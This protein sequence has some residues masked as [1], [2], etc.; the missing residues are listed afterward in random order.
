MKIQSYLLSLSLLSSCLF[1]TSCDDDDNDFNG[2][3]EITDENRNANDAST[4]ASLARWEM[5]ATDTSCDY[6]THYTSDGLL[7]YAMEY[8]KEKMH[9]RWVAYRYDSKLKAQV[10]SRS[11]EWGVEPFYNNNKTYQI[12]TGFFGGYNRGHLVGSA[13]RLYSHEANVQTFYMSNM[14]PMNGNFNSIYW[15]EIETLVRNWG[16]NCGAGDTL[17]VV[18]GGTLDSLLTTTTVK[19]TLG[20]TVQMAVPKYYYIA[21]LSL[22]SEGK[23]KAIGFWIEHKDFKDSSLSN[24]KKIRQAA[25]CTIDELE[26]RTGIDFFCNVPDCIENIVEARYTRSSWPGL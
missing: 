18:K 11:D 17:Y 3:I 8:S 6:I 7:N 26:E 16:R 21:V 12:A 20:E 1:I 2:K 15:G 4:D 10:T 22:S 25:A 14:S 24:L 9:S 5:P 19:N 13:E 23:A